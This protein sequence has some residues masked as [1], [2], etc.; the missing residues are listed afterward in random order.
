MGTGLK[1]FGELRD[2]AG[3]MMPRHNPIF[4]DK[5]GKSTNGFFKG[6]GIGALFTVSYYDALGFYKICLHYN[7][8][9]GIV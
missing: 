6:D 9:Y 4:R 5:K 7:H 8:Y 2:A 1:R 3:M